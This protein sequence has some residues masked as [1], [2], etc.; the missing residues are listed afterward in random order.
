M[1]KRRTFLWP[2]A[3]GRARRIRLK[4]QANPTSRKKRR[5]CDKL[6]GLSSES[7]V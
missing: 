6:V 5:I 7:R 2:N 3:R 1:R 4:L